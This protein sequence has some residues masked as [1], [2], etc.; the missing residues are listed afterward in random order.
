MTKFSFNLISI[1]LLFSH[2]TTST[3]TTGPSNVT[4][5]NEHA[6]FSTFELF[7]NTKL[8]YPCP[9]SAQA[10]SNTLVPRRGGGRGGGGGSGGGGGDG[11]GGGTRVASLV[12]I[13]WIRNEADYCKALSGNVIMIPTLPTQ[14]AFFPWFDFLP[15]KH[16]SFIPNHKY[17]VANVRGSWSQSRCYLLWPVANITNSRQKPSPRYEISCCLLGS[18]SFRCCSYR[19]L[20][21]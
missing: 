3:T 7:K 19:C 9:G 4:F 11:G 12:S 14:T 1:A 15:P 6:Q 10:S 20:V 16:H 8:F 21:L 17:Q 2:F 5:F 18:A 13:K